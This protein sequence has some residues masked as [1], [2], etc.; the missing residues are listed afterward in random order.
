MVLASRVCWGTSGHPGASE[1]LGPR[2]LRIPARFLGDSFVIPLDYRRNSKDS[3]KPLNKTLD[4]F[5]QISKV[6]HW[7]LY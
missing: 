2:V 5:L 3:C 7:G 6:F 1:G 4:V